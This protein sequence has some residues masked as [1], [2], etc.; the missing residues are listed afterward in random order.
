[1]FSEDEGDQEGPETHS[2]S[3]K[4]VRKIPSNSDGR[5]AKLGEILAAFLWVVEGALGQ[6][7]EPGKK[8]AVSYQHCSVTGSPYRNAENFEVIE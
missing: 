1:M 8:A 3:A 7:V 4:I 5:G 6:V 2:V